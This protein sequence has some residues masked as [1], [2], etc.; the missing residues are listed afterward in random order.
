MAAR[1]RT[2]ALVLLAV[3]G[4]AAHAQT[5]AAKTLAESRNNVA[6]AYDPLSGADFDGAGDAFSG[7]ALQLAGVTPGATVTAD[8]MDFVWPD[9]ASGEAD[10]VEAR[11]QSIAISGPAGA[12]RLGLLA[13]AHGGDVRATLRLNYVDAAGVTGVETVT[14]DIADWVPDVTSPTVSASH[15]VSTDFYVVQSA[16]P[17]PISAGLDA[18]VVPLDR[19]RTLVS[20]DLP[21]NAG[22]HVFDLRTAAGPGSGQEPQELP[23][24][25]TVAALPAGNLTGFAPRSITVFQ[26]QPLDFTNLDP[27]SSHDVISVRRGPDYKRLFTS[28]SIPAGATTRVEG[29]EKL[30]LGTYDFV[31]SVHGSM[32]GQLT[33]QAAP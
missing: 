15:D 32:Q 4:S 25:S 17:V 20:V 10:N 12:T 16:L 2:L 11:G 1:A 21:D 8:D 6:V 5:P 3:A 24:H 19:F 30:P 33:V 13:A 29:V 9:T 31:C 18:V 23:V 22:L 7:V 14:V 28:D 27:T 26:G